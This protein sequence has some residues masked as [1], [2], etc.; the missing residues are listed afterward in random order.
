MA[1]ALETVGC[2]PVVR[3]SFSQAGARACQGARTAL[4]GEDLLQ[5][6]KSAGVA[7]HTTTRAAK[8]TTK[9]AAET[10]KATKRVVGVSKGVSTQAAKNRW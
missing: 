8:N 3:K 7:T 5:A 10:A 2:L 9:A 1:G 6:S 4:V